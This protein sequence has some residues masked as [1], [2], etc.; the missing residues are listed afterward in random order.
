MNCDYRIKRIKTNE[1]EPENFDYEAKIFD[2]IYRND[3]MRE[4]K[5]YK[6]GIEVIDKLNL[7]TR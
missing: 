2:Y 7:R 4:I 5:Y 1:I 6:N 3:K